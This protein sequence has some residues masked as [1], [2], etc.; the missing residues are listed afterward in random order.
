MSDEQLSVIPSAQFGEH[1]PIFKG[2]LKKNL[3][4]GEIEGEQEVPLAIRS[5]YLHSRSLFRT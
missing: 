1:R 4:I 2:D 3:G 5:S